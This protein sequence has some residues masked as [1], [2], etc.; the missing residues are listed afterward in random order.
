MSTPKRTRSELRERFPALFGVEARDVQVEVEDLLTRCVRERKSCM[1]ELPTGAGK[2]LVGLYACIL[3][4][5][6]GAAHDEEEKDE[7]VG[8]DADSTT[9]VP[10]AR[11]K[12]DGCAYVCSSI[13]LQR[14]ICQEAKAHACLGSVFTLL[15]TSNYFCAARVA[16][17]AE[18]LAKGDEAVASLATALGSVRV[19]AVRAYL[20]EL[21]EITD[22]RPGPNDPFWYT[23]QHE[24]W[25]TKAVALRLD[26]ALAAEV[27]S[28][29]CADVKKCECM[30]RAFELAERNFERAKATVKCPYQV[31]RRVHASTANL[32]VINMSLLCT[33]AAHG[34]DKLFGRFF[35]IDE[36]HEL[37]EKAEAIYDSVGL[38]PLK[39]ATVLKTIQEWHGRGISLV[40]PKDYDLG[41]FERIFR[42]AQD[43]AIAFG[44]EGVQKALGAST[45]TYERD[46]FARAHAWIKAAK[47]QVD[48][49]LAPLRAATTAE[50]REGEV[51]KLWVDG[52][53][54]VAKLMNA[55]TFGAV[56]PAKV[57]QIVADRLF[58][59]KDAQVDLEGY[60]RRLYMAASALAQ[61]PTADEYLK[62]LGAI[63]RTIRALV[64]AKK[65]ARRETWIGDAAVRSITPE[66]SNAGI[67]FEISLKDKA[68]AIESKLWAQFKWAPL[69]MSATLTHQR[70]FGPFER[71][72]GLAPALSYSRPS[73][74]PPESRVFVVPRLKCPFAPQ[75]MRGRQAEPGYKEKHETE[76][77]EHVARAVR[78]NPKSTLVIGPSFEDLT[79]LR[80][81]LRR[82]LP[83]WRHIEFRDGEQFD[84]FR[85]GELGDDARA[86]V[87]GSMNLATGV[88][89]PGRIGLVVV[90]RALQLPLSPAELYAKQEL[91]EGSEMWDQ[92]Y[93]RSALRFEQAA[94]R[95]VRTAS[96]R[97]VVLYF[98][99][100]APRD[101]ASE[102]ELVRERFGTQ[103]VDRLDTWP[104]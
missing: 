103:V 29:V 47:A 48:E 71:R 86:I 83:E 95:L 16:K 21:L 18:A 104:H 60:E 30:D 22:A 44:N 99:K 49:A 8:S 57:A 55:D 64:F 90:L 59:Q 80:F 41:M 63:E 12:Y 75:K 68:V 31:A 54:Q 98:S 27:W 42:T 66:A 58:A 19:A 72:V 17:F 38:P 13:N 50:E 40:D 25:K 93:A 11:P 14:Q 35:V 1:L 15:G 101:L 6:I 7:D 33:Y 24:R 65:A 26:E 52:P 92:Y 2:S 20:D 77:F 23:S 62:E 100:G 3:A 76:V 89:L 10:A 73:V 67:R 79:A 56:E 32:L 36:A 39:A 61:P 70:S 94:G 5:E 34:I 43:R 84:R 97:G 102:H 53:E 51:R 85:Q 96:D 87:Y 82:A 69:L 46:A 88:D 45:L 91:G 28:H 78:L 74:F 81:R 37:P 4:K 9:G